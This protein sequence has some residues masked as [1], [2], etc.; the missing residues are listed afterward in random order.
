[1]KRI[2]LLLVILSLM[3]SCA[4]PTGAAF[5]LDELAI[6]ETIFDT[7]TLEVTHEIELIDELPVEI[8]D[9]LAEPVV[10]LDPPIVEPPPVVLPVSP[11][12][13]T[14]FKATGAHVHL[15][16]LYNNSSAMASLDGV[17]LE[18]IASG[19]EYEVPLV[20]GWIE[21]RS[22]VV[23]AWQ[24][25]S[26]NADIIFQF[27][28]VGDGL[29]ESITLIHEGYQT[30][31]VPVPTGYGG[32]LL[33]RFKSAAGNYTT[34]LTFSAGEATVF[35]GGLYTLPG[36][37]DLSVLEVLVNPRSCVYGAETPD[38]Y[39]YI[40]LRNDGAEPLDLGLYRLRS[41]FSNSSSTTTNT[42]YFS[43]VLAPGEVHTLAYDRDGKRISFT[44]NDGTVWLEDLYG[45]ESYDLHVPPYVGS[46]LTAHIGRSWAYNEQVDAW[47]WATPS[48]ETEEN[49][50]TI[51][52]AG[53][54]EVASLA[55]CGEG[56]ERNPATGR[57]RNI[58]GVS[59]LAP[60]R[61]GQY[62]SEE[63]NRCRSIATAAASVLRPCADDQFRN[64]KTNRCKKIASADDIALADCGEGRERNPATNRCRNV[65]G[66]S[67]LGD[68]LPFPVERVEEGRERFVGWWTVGIVVLAGVGYG[69]WEWRE[70]IAGLRKRATRFIGR[71]K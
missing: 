17:S 49:N 21:P 61:E 70:E 71:S 14:A 24:G 48:P 39:D 20:S 29:L 53:K 6:E 42:T 22:Y 31:T 66:V 34:N 11:F 16:Q 2:A 65:L 32:Q 36:A 33:H 64:P 54:G 62:R 60:C 9:E 51:I 43:E 1:M 25:E 19:D 7:E 26:P 46:T 45:Y 47:Q 35:G 27:P 56:R 59:E 63:T 58:P 40:K 10:P 3:I 67:T 28:A 8:E 15:V 13:I 5:A 18:Y 50:F 37:P 44:A 38:C 55:D 52:E 30:L 69:L 12:I 68:T 4:A 23:I 41:G 57:C